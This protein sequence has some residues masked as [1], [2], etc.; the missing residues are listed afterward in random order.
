[1]KKTSSHGRA[2]AAK[3]A[4]KAAAGKPRLSKFAAKQGVPA[5]PDSPFAVLSKLKDHRQ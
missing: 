5:D 2:H 4:A 3:L 1:M